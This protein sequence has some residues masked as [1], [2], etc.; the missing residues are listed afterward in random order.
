M[1]LIDQLNFASHEDVQR[2]AFNILDRIQNEP[3]GQQLAASGL[4]F[5]LICE[6]FKV[7]PREVLYKSSSVLLDALSN[8][9]GEQTRAMQMYLREEFK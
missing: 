3:G 8:G 1:N 6:R 2:L 7:S 4:F 5:L 9:T